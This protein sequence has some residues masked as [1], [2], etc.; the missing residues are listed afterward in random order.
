MKVF[1]VIGNGFDLN[2]KMK[3]EYK[4]FLQHYNTIK[5]ESENIN[6]LKKSI[7]K[8]FE[9]WA[10][11]ELAFGN[12][13]EKIKTIDEL[14]EI[15]EDLLDNLADYLKTQEEN[16]DFSKGNPS[17]LYNH[18]CRPEDSLPEADKKIIQKF[19]SNWAT[20]QWTIRI[21]TLNYTRTIEKI[22]GESDFNFE[23][24]NHSNSQKI[25]LRSIEHIHGYYDKRMILGINDTSQLKNTIFHTNQDVLDSIIKID[26]NKAYKHTIDE[27][28]KSQIEVA[29]LICIFGTSMGDTDNYW[30]ELIGNQLKRSDCILL[31]FAHGNQTSPNKGYKNTRIER[32]VKKK[33]LSKL[34]LSEEEMQNAMDKIFVGVNTNL[35]GNILN[36]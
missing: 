36:D 35:F 5:S 34:N 9:T 27:Q 18:L 32:N 15:F 17:A 16:F 21:M 31:I 20:Y 33:F 28:C 23:I 1:Y 22:I 25:I 2:L 3:T 30:W 26:C 6:D 11:L 4:D 29:N 10:N 14:D 19:K 24:G 7:T 13:V 12:Y 8:D